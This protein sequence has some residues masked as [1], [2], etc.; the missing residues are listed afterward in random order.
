MKK[1]RGITRIAFPTILF[2]QFTTCGKPPL[3]RLA[4][5]FSTRS[6]CFTFLG[7]SSF[8]ELGDLRVSSFSHLVIPQLQPV[9]KNCLF[10]KHGSAR[11]EQI[12]CS[13]ITLRTVRGT[14]RVNNSTFR[15]LA[16]YAL[17]PKRL[18]KSEPNSAVIRLDVLVISPQL[19]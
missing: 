2:W 7:A 19:E 4:D 12:H 8:S 10:I 14:G 16:N 18:P 6:F 13:H 5:S 9:R 3:F 15:N 1:R 17:F 11:E